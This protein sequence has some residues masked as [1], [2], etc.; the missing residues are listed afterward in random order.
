MLP[1]C[2]TRKSTPAYANIKI[3]GTNSRCQRTKDAAI[4]SR[5]NQELKFQY[6]K[7]QQLHERLYKLHLE[8]TA[9]W[10]NTW[11]IIQ[12]TIDDNIQQQMDKHYV[13]I[14]KKLDQLQ[15]KQPRRPAQQQ[16][17]E[18][19]RFYTRVKNVT[20]IKFDKE[21]MQLLKYGLNYSIE[22]PTSTYMA[23]LIAET[24]RA[25]RLL[26]VKEQNAYRIMA[27]KKLKQINSSSNHSNVLQKDNF[28]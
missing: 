13:H 24:E 25:I 10:P 27:T 3:K 9:Q 20:N 21:E 23:S 15:Q 16:P 22:Q 17:N 1:E 7:K 18:E 19:H 4:R 28:T 11:Q 6:A 14:N 2:R 8:C 12:S 26:D 5:I